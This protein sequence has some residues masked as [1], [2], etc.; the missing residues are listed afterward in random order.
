MVGLTAAFG[1]GEAVSLLHSCSCFSPC[2]FLQKRKS[3]RKGIGCVIDPSIIFILTIRPS[4]LVCQKP[5][6]TT[7]CEIFFTWHFPC[8]FILLRNMVVVS[9]YIFIQ[10]FW[11]HANSKVKTP[12]PFWN[13]LIRL[14]VIYATTPSHSWNFTGWLLYVDT[15]SDKHGNKWRAESS[16]ALK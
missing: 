6:G 7:F 16:D 1:E 4:N 2:K 8:Y 11:S 12:K 15:G 13:A 10:I 9:F 14:A 3:G 5:P